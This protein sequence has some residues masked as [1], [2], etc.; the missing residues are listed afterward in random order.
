MWL[1]SAPNQ[2]LFRGS[3]STFYPIR[4]PRLFSTG[5]LPSDTDQTEAED[6]EGGDDGEFWDREVDDVSNLYETILAEIVDDGRVG[7]IT[8]NRPEVLNALST[9]VM[10]ELADVLQELDADPR[11]KAIILTGSGKKAF[12]AG[13]DIKE[14][15]DQ[16][17][18]TAYLGRLL[19]GYERATSECRTPIIAAVNG[20]ALGGGCELAMMCDIILAGENAVFGQPETNLGVIPGMGGTQRLI[21]AVGKSRAMEMILSGAHFIDAEEAVSRGLASRV[22]TG[23]PEKL[24]EAAIDLAKQIARLSGPVVAMAKEAVNSANDLGLSEGVKKENLFFS[25]CFGLYDQKEGMSAF[26]EKRKA[27]FENR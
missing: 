16:E 17:F 1:Q 12:A 21:R 2:A 6:A 22:I 9:Q 20:Y 3:S 8:I 15:R 4:S 26:L 7:I 24:I 13:A 10:D 25:A 19:S 5:R 11:V 18:V 27:R 23:G 14:M